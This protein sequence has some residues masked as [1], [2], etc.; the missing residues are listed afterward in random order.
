MV[1]ISQR[2]INLALKKFKISHGKEKVENF[3][4]YGWS[5]GRHRGAVGLALK[6]TVREIS[7][8]GG[9]HNGRGNGRNSSENIREC[10]WSRQPNVV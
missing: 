1:F 4:F 2:I 8:V 10:Q 5:R 6:D 3:V 7:G 9:F